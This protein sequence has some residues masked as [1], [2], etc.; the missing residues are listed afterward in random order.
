MTYLMNIPN[1]L[2]SFLQQNCNLYYKDANVVM[3]IVIG[4]TRVQIL[5]KAF[6]ISHTGN[7]PGKS[8]NATILPPH[9]MNSTTHD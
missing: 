7:T 3:V 6:S 5:N 2:W 8:M 4:A 9:Y 1:A